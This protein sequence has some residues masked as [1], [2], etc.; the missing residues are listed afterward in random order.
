[1]NF[2]FVSVLLS[3]LSCRE[4]TWSSRTLPKT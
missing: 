3:L 4:F 2:G 1:M